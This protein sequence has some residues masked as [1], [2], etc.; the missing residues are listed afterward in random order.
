MGESLLQVE[1]SSSVSHECGFACIAEHQ[2]R[3]QDALELRLTLSMHA[4]HALSSAST[5][6]TSEI[7]RYA[8]FERVDRLHRAIVQQCDVRTLDVVEERIRRIEKRY[9][10]R[11]FRDKRPEWTQLPHRS[12]SRGL[13]NKSGVIRLMLHFSAGHPRFQRYHRWQVG[14]QQCPCIAL[15]R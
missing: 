13:V 14:R 6:T 5:M 15:V 12:A 9:R 3:E 7:G 10:Q 4:G 11:N 2:L 8:I 1:L